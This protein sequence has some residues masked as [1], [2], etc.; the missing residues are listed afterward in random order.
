MKQ[1]Y[2]EGINLQINK[3]KLK[4]IRHKRAGSPTLARSTSSFEASFQVWESGR[5]ALEEA[6]GEY[7]SLKLAVL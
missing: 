1:I 7:K 5:A 6:D 2:S 3:A 4:E